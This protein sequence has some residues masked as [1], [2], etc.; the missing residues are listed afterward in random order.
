[1]NNC[2]KFRV[3]E[4]VLWGKR[5]RGEVFAMCLRGDNILNALDIKNADLSKYKLNTGSIVS[6]EDRYIIKSRNRLDSFS[7]GDF[8]SMGSKDG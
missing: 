2:P 3:G 7:V 8:D 1:M 6:S 4:K 5:N